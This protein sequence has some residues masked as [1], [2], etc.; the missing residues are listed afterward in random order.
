MTNI[1]TAQI[2]IQ[3]IRPLLWNAFTPEAIPLHKVEKTGVAGNDPEEWRKKVLVTKQ[4]QLYLEPTYIFGCLRDGAR[5]TRKGRSSLQTTLSATL[6]IAN[7]RVLVDRFLPPEDALNQDAEQP[8]Y[9]DVRSVRNPVTRARNVRYRVAASAG[10]KATFTIQWDK[11]VVSRQ[12][13][14]AVVVDAGQLAG[15]GDGRAVGFG[16]FMLQAFEIV[17]QPASARIMA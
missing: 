1:L 8:V 2:T 13:M 17:N 7:D 5:H 12:E 10:W 6:Q 9:L 11:T 16:R 15:L 14:E 4:R 3:G